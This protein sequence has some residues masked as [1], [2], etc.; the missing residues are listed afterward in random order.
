MPFLL[1]YN[2]TEP[3]SS[4]KEGGGGGGP[5]GWSAIRETGNP[6]LIFFPYFVI[7]RLGGACLSAALASTV[8]KLVRNICKWRFLSVCS[9]E[10]IFKSFPVFL[11]YI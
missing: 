10:T 2:Y 4:Y 3:R 5:G 9:R 1:P 8:C 7:S 6:S 11:V